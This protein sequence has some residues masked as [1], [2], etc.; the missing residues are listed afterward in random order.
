MA[1]TFTICVIGGVLAPS[2]PIQHSTLEL[3]LPG[4]TWI[5]F[6]SFVLGLI[7][8]FLFGVYAGWGLALLHNVF[9]R[10]EARLRTL[11]V[12]KA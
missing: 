12:N 9:T 4:F 10:R 3:L 2:L 11:G 1:F 7:E 6:G 8:S 5:S